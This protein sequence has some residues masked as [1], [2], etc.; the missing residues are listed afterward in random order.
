MRSEILNRLH[1]GDLG[2]VR[3][4]SMARKCVFWPEISKDIKEMIEK[5]PVCAKFQIGSEEY[6]TSDNIPESTPTARPQE[7]V[8]EPASDFQSSQESSSQEP[9]S[10]SPDRIHIDPDTA[11]M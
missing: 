8:A 5:C 1:E 2:F 3:T 4:I 11:E 7:P 9:I 6:S 10:R